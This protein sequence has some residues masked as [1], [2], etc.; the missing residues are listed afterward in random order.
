MGVSVS[1]ANVYHLHVTPNIEST[2]V[3]KIITYL[4]GMGWR[5]RREI[6]KATGIE[7]G[8]VSGRVNKLVG[9]KVLQE[10]GFLMECPVTGRRVK[11]VRLALG[12][13]QDFFQ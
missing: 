5:S 13:Q 8:A 4:R 3:E 10:A 2:Q 6:S 11:M 9:A 12:D 7:P 1:S